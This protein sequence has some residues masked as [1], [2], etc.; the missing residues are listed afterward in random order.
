MKRIPTQWIAAA[1][2]IGL[3]VS[4]VALAAGE[5]RAHPRGRHHEFR[6]GPGR[7][8]GRHMER[9][10]RVRDRFMAHIER[11]DLSDEQRTKLKAI[12]RSAPAALSPKKLAVV[13]ARMDLH[14]LMSQEKADAQAI[15]KANEKLQ[16]ARAELQAAAFELRL[17]AREVLTPEQRKELR[18][19]PGPGPRRGGGGPRGMGFDDLDEDSG[20]DL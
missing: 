19:L 3:G 8:F 11:L 20:V 17:Q 15:R 12:R 7:D 6:Q 13:E 9:G 10:E 16:K 4:L 14:D 2:A 18:Q 1:A 5:V